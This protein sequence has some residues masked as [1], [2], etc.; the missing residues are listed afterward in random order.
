LRTAVVDVQDVYDE[1]NYAIVS[2][3][4]IQNFVRFAYENWEPPPRY[5]LLFGDGHGDYMD[6]YGTHQPNFI[7]PHYSWIPPLG[8]MPDDDWFGCVKGDDAFAE[9]SV[10]RLPV[11]SLAEGETIVEKIIGYDSVSVPQEWQKKMTFCASAGVTFQAGC[12]SIAEAAPANFD[13]LYLFRDD[14]PNAASMKQGI[15]GALDVGTSV[16]FYAGHGNVERWLE[17]V[18]HV[19]DMPLFTNAEKLP[20]MC[21]LICLSGY[22]AVPWYECLAEELVRTTD[23]GTV[24][25]I[26]PTGAAHLSEHLI[27][28]QEVLRRIC[29]GVTLG[30][31][32]GEAKLN[33]YTRGLS[34]SFL[35]GFGLIGDPATSPRFVSPTPDLLWL[36]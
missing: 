29:A 32:L 19:S 27:L 11:R 26:A 30:Q 36:Y 7:L 35:R 34:E 5:L 1:F 12:Q 6:W 17:D 28:G 31:C 22:F 10:G 24:A 14:F 9:V 23:G 33:S 3:E 16:F 25:C 4:A 8:W 21:M 15:L 18:L 2:P 13:R 20:I